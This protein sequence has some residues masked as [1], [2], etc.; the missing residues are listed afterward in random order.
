MATYGLLQYEDGFTNAKSLDWAGFEP[1]FATGSKL[2][3]FQV[4]QDWKKNSAVRDKYHSY[5][6]PK[7]LVYCINT[8]YLENTIIL[9]TL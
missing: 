8:K 6:K 2:R 3:I 1:W 5:F 9:S 7:W 4:E